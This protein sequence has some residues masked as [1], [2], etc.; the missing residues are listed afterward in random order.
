MLSSLDVDY[1]LVRQNEIT[2]GGNVGV[3]VEYPCCV[4]YTSD[5]FTI[6]KGKLY[7]LHYNDFPLKVPETLPLANKM[8][9]SFQINTGQEDMSNKSVF[10]DTT[11]NSAFE[12]FQN[13]N[14][15]PMSLVLCRDPHELEEPQDVPPQP[16]D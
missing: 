6:A 16:Q 2:I 3:K 4:F 8:V 10:E 9:E 13:K 14:C 1:N 15:P 7:V 11:N 12:N 5:I